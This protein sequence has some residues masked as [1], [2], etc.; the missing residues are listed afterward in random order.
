MDELIEILED[1]RPDV[2]FQSETRL[3]DN[4]ILESLDIVVL[5]GEIRE[6]FDVS[7]SAA[8]L[9]PENFNSAQSIWNLICSLQD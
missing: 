9:T 1:L 4:H 8:D 5:V 2:D 3:V 6:A 7:V